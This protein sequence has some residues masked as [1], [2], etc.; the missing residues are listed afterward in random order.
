MNSPAA[1][2]LYVSMMDINFKGLQGMSA[3]HRAVIQGHFHI[4]VLLMKAG[5]DPYLKDDAGTTP[6]D[7]ANQRERTDMIQVL[8]NRPSFSTFLIEVYV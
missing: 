1:N 6:I 2:S 4:V 3:L 7:Y 5:A 8:N